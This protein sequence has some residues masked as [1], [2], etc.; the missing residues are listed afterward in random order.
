MRPLHGLVPEQRPNCQGLEM[1]GKQ[2]QEENE[3]VMEMKNKFG[4]NIQ[5]KPDG[6]FRCSPFAHSKCAPFFE[7]L[8]THLNQYTTICVESIFLRWF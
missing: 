1:R 7:F 6:I 4:A 3:K 5:L 2:G 8:C